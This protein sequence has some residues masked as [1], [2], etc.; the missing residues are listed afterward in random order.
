MF[1]AHRLRLKSERG[2]GLRT[3]A[4]C[5]YCST[6]S[7]ANAKGIEVL[8]IARICEDY[9]YQLKSQKYNFAMHLNLGDTRTPWRESVNLQVF[10]GVSANICN[11]ARVNTFNILGL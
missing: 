10:L 11:F 1:P 2:N 3:V 6:I 8:R 7:H 9:V 5:F 4:F